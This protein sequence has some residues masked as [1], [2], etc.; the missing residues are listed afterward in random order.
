MI[1]YQKNRKRNC[2]LRPLLTK[3]ILLL[4]TSNHSLCSISYRSCIVILIKINCTK[5]SIRTVVP[6]PK[7]ADRTV[8]GSGGAG[9]SICYVMLN[10]VLFLILQDFLRH[11]CLGLILDV[12]L[13]LP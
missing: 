11:I 5:L 8:R 2:G 7:G 13:G 9:I 12:F 3:V 4:I 1:Q 10:N 6:K